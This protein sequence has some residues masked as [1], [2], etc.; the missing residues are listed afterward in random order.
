MAVL[1]PCVA[2]QL[3]ARFT[4]HLVVMP[5]PW[6]LE[7]DA[8]VAKLVSRWKSTD[9]GSSRPKVAKF[10]ARCAEHFVAVP[11]PPNFEANG[12]DRYTSHVIFLMHFLH[13]IRCAYSLHGSR[14]ATQFVC[15][16]RTHS[17]RCVFD[18]LLVASSFC[19]SPVSLCC[20]P[21]LFL[22]LPVL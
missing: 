7:E 17:I 21:L 11:M 20:L 15:V 3:V 19:P 16:A 22:I 18:C 1:V 12:V 8:E 2:E 4:E 13:T 14:R 6:I 9:R 10:C 5:A